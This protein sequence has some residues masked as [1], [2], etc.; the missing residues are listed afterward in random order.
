MRWS[1]LLPLPLLEQAAS[2]VQVLV[3]SGAYS[4]RTLDA[5]IEERSSYAVAVT[6]TLLP[7]TVVGTLPT[8]TTGGVQS[9]SAEMAACVVEVL[10]QIASEN[11]TPNSAVLAR[12]RALAA[13][14]IRFSMANRAPGP[15]GGRS[16]QG[17]A[18]PCPAGS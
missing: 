8:V 18:R 11:W 9:F 10:D 5:S 7:E 14:R 1:P 15:M 12:S 13:T 3:P 17:S 2:A 6:E 4:I 16:D